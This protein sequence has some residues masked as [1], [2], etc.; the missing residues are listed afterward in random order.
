M[1]DL[2]TTNK[3]DFF[4]EG[5]HFSYLEEQVLPEWVRRH[6]G[7]ARRPIRVWSAGCSSGEE[8]YTLAMVLQNFRELCPGFDY[9]I[10]G[11]DISTS[12]LETAR[13]AVYREERADTVPPEFRKKYLLRSK[14]RSDRVVRIAPLL[15]SRVQFRFL[16]FMEDDFGIAE[17]FDVIFCRNVIIYFDRSTQEAFLQRLSRHVAV[18]GHLFLGHSETLSGYD[19]PLKSVF[20]TVYTRL[21]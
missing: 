17:L 8:P 5:E 3:T 2:V 18:G 15:R 11:T 20:P 10:L 7:E 13:L 19:L 16:N 6:P 9:R 21:S 14:E 12:V 1:I 4:R